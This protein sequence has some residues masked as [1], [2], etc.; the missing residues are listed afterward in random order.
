MSEMMPKYVQQVQV[1]S[2][3]HPPVVHVICNS[4][5]MHEEN[6]DKAADHLTAPS[7]VGDLLQRAGG[8]DPS[9]RSGACS[10]LPEGPHQ[11]S[12]QEHD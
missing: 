1:S 2:C 12:V 11:R 5:L 9:G 7:L 6:F 10:D 8:D 4:E 3:A